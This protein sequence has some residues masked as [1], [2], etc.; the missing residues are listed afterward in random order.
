MYMPFFKKSDLFYF[1]P[2]APFFRAKLTR[3]KQLTD[4]GLSGKW[5]EKFGEIFFETVNNPFGVYIF[6]LQIYLRMFFNFLKP[7]TEKVVENYL[8]EHCPSKQTVSKIKKRLNNMLISCYF[9]TGGKLM[10]YI[11]KSC[12][13]Q[14]GIGMDNWL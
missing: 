1:R 9:E 6:C 12:F 2:A 7:V 5:T 14:W 10:W 8:A 4:C 3:T 11:L 13:F